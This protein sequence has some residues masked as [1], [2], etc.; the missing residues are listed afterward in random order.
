[1]EL[2]RLPKYYDSDIPTGCCP[3]FKSEGWDEQ[4]LHFKN[5]L[6]VKTTTRSFFHIP[7]NMGSVFTN[8]FKEIENADAIDMEQ[9][10]ILSIDVSPWKA[11]HYFAVTKEVPGQE[12][13]Q[14]S[15]DYFTKVFE[16]AYKNA[17]NWYK[18]MQD[19]VKQKGKAPGKVYFFYTTCPKCAKFYGKNYV[20]GFGEAA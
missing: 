8:V 6:F 15:G 4:E 17:R 14:L 16:G 10:A 2:N 7:I 5:K 9:V 1:M 18:E 12:N 3:R 19:F 13:V 11:E 20:I